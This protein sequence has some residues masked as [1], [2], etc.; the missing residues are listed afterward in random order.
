MMVIAHT[1]RSKGLNQVENPQQG[2]GSEPKGT[3]K[4][5]IALDTKV[6]SIPLVSILQLV[7]KL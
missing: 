3:A 1:F 6:M 7:Q 5:L 4:L 2:M